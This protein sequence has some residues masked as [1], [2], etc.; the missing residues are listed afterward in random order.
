MRAGPYSHIS[1]RRTLGSGDTEEVVMKEEARLKRNTDRL[2]ECFPAYA[3][4]VRRVLDVM[5]AHNFRPR[6]QDG[7]RSEADQL[8]AF[9][10]GASDVKFGFHNVTGAG[11]K[12]ERFACDVIDDDHPFAMTTRYFLTLA[13]AARSVG[14]ET[15]ILWKLPQA[16]VNGIEAALAAGNL[17]ASVKVG[18]DPTHVQP[19]GITIAE[20]KRGV[21]PSFDGAPVAPVAAMR[22]LNRPM[23]PP[24]AAGGK[25]HTV[26]AGETLSKIAKAHGLTLARILELN[27]ELVSH[28]NLIHVGDRVRIK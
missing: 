10:A 12:K 14:L 2:P 11:G 19:T 9:N 4:R 13:G 22:D 17:D 7:W 6:I 3:T 27:P 23:P 25:F 8:I 20:A 5:E 26:V 21:R 18:F 1:P 28:P 16:L 24:P 15:G